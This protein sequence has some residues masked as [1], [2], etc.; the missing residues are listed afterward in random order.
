MSNQHLRFRAEPPCGQGPTDDATRCHARCVG[1]AP[2]GP[3]A[4]EA[5]DQHLDNGFFDLSIDMLC[6]AG[7][8]GRFRRLNPAW[9]KTLGFTIEELLS[10]PMLELVHP[11]DRERTAEQNHQ[12]RAGG[13]ARVFENRYVCSDGSYRWLR[14]NAT[15]D[16][17]K[18]LIYSLARDITDHKREEEEREKLLREL[19]AALAAVKELEKILP[20]C[21]YCRSVRD[22][23]DYWQTVESYISRHTDTQ[24][25]HGICP[26][27]YEKV[28]EPQLERLRVG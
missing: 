3:A 4:V 14:W 24:F 8:S 11:E 23:Q 25:S 18:R 21:S 20:I 17:D 28:V 2:A 1:G 5:D 16:L 22:D 10:R 7:F 12:V 15:A 19:Q 13:E 9:Q 27:C 6:V 26:T